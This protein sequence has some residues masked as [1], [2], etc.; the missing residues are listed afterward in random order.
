MR[1][2]I[3]VPRKR[4]KN[5]L[6]QKAKG[7]TGGRRRLL[8]SGQRNA[9]AGRGVRLP[10]PPRTQARVPQ[11]VD[12]PHQRGLPRTR[13]ALQRVHQRPAPRPTSSST[14][15]RSP[16][17]RSTTRRRSTRSS[18]KPKRRL[19]S[20]DDGTSPSIKPRPPVAVWPVH[21]AIERALLQPRTRRQS[22]SRG[23][24][25]P[26]PI[27]VQIL[28]PRRG[29][30]QSSLRDVAP[31]GLRMVNWCHV[32]GAHAP[33]YTTS[34]P[35][36]P[37]NCLAT[38]CGGVSDADSATAM[39]DEI[40]LNEAAYA[41]WQTV[42]ERGPIEL[43]EVARLTGIDQ[44]QV[45]AAATEAAEQRLLQDR[46]TR[47]RGTDPSATSAHELVEARPAR[48][49]R[50]AE[51]LEQSGGQ[52]PMAEFT[53]WAKSEVCRRQRSAQMGHGSRMDSK[54]TKDASW[55]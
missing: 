51:S 13:P 50:A 19:R 42:K 9:R 1:T 14:A 52:M 4:K 31:P 35:S 17:W 38:P 22:C 46:G 24:K 16:S 54:A 40:L 36:G 48:A 18:K 55:H 39:P 28:K 3:G 49:S 10:R 21:H 32:P 29:D 33:G 11:A 7:Y 20:V 12:H 47:A 27:V 41:V 5:R 30:S 25:P 6:F 44:A 53:A 45:S 23:R 37:S 8:R 43:G 15:R 2:T 34:A 26:V